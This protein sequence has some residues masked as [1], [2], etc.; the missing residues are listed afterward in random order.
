MAKKKSQVPEAPK[1]C[2][3]WTVLTEIQI[4]GR[5]VIPGT[6]LKISGESGRF[7][8]VKYVKTE[9]DVEWIDVVGGKKQYESFRSFRMDRVKTV[10]SKNKT[11]FH[12]AKK[13]KEK[14]KLLKESSK[15]Q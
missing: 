1:P 8:F 12:M 5:N 13:Y 14:Q 3:K 9:K 10:H 11:D 2:D 6:E 15:S 4:N 7:R